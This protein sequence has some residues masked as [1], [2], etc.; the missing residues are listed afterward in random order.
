MSILERFEVITDSP[1]K[2]MDLGERIGSLLME[3]DIISLSGELGSGKTT[4]IQGIAKGLSIKEPVNSPTFSL[5]NIY[6]GRLPLYHFDLYRIKEGEDIGYDDFFNSSA[7]C[8]IEWGEKASKFLQD[9]YLKISLSHIDINPVRSELP[10]S[11]VTPSVW[12]SKGVNTRR[13]LFI[14]KGKHFLEL[15]KNITG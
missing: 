15:V 3:G 14:P 6:K 10:K 1:E 5:L 12:I 7:I 2:T 4:L 11:T 9:N 13:I 8:V